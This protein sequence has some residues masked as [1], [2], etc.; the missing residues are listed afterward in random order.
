M[1]RVMPAQFFLSVNSPKLDVSHEESC[2]ATTLGLGPVYWPTD[3]TI[4]MCKFF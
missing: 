3:Y 2:S 4:M 1:Q